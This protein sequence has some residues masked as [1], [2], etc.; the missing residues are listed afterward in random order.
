V[1]LG[2]I[3][4]LGALYYLVSGRGRPHDIESAGA[5]TGEAVIG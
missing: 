4:L 1:I 2:V 5:A 3:P